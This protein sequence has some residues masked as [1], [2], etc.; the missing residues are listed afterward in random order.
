MNKNDGLKNENNYS[1]EMMEIRHKIINIFSKELDIVGNVITKHQISN[2]IIKEGWE[3]PTAPIIKAFKS[4]TKD[5]LLK[6]TDNAYS[7]ALTEKGYTFLIN[8]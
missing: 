6:I 5:G 1:S 4:L 7:W 3:E 2:L 8:S